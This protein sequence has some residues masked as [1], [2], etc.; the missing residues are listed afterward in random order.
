MSAESQI[1]M[2]RHMYNQAEI[3]AGGLRENFTS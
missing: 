2:E 3:N 1:Y